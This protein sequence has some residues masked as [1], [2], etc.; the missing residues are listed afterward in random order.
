MKLRSH[1]PSKDKST[2]Q[3]EHEDHLSDI[4]S[5]S[6]SKT[7]PSSCSPVNLD[8]SPTVVV[9]TATTTTTTSI[10]EQH[11]NQLSDIS[12]QSSSKTEPSSCLPVNYD[13]S[14]T[15]V[16]GTATTNTNSSTIESNIDSPSH[17]NSQSALLG[18]AS[19]AIAT[20]QDRVI[21]SPPKD[22]IK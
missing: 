4:S 2:I 1:L 11:E 18:L 3:E 20:I 12:N 22:T 21:T 9:S 10:Q 17:P 15:V 6:S 14:P 16:A 7:E 5:Q 13:L 8:L 19:P